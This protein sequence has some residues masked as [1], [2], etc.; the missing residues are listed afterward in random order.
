MIL[1]ATCY[2]V[3]LFLAADSQEMTEVLAA[4]GAHLFLICASVI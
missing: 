3:H 2:Y 1:F 4:F